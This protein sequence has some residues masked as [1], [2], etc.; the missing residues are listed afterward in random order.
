MAQYSTVWHLFLQSLDAPRVL[1]EVRRL[2]TVQYDRP[3]WNA[4]NNTVVLEMYLW[5][6]LCTL[7]LLAC[8]ARVGI[9]G[10]G[11]CCVRVASFERCLT[12]LFLDFVFL[13]FSQCRFFQNI[14]NK[15][16]RRPVRFRHSNSYDVDKM[17]Y[18]CPLCEGLSNSVIPIIPYLPTLQREGWVCPFC[19]NSVI[20][21]ILYLP[22]LLREGWVCPFCN[23]SVIPIIPYLPTLQREGWVCPFCINSVTPHPVFTHSTTWGVS[24]SFL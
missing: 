23:N 15:E 4:L 17:E 24:V 7:Y 2:S 1:A 16:R 10:L 5:W 3:L 22:T 9:G 21:V 18:L 11:L 8:Q 19:N 6:R 13:W 12:P 20:P 14:V